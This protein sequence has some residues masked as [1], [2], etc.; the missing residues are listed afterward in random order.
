MEII[1]TKDFLRANPVSVVFVFGDNHSR[2]GL[3]GA[4]QFRHFHNTYGFI[5]K[6]LPRNNN[7]AF[8]EPEEYERVFLVE[9]AKLETEMIKYPNKKFLLSKIGSG[10]ANRF[11]IF[12]EVIEP[13]LDCLRHYDNLIFLW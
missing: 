8:Y 2:T 13:G 1:I 11:H 5:T 9:R 12:E 4:A 6:K 7:G 10:L 3:G